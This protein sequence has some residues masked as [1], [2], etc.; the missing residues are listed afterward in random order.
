MVLGI[1]GMPDIVGSKLALLP[2]KQLS[3]S[4]TQIDGTPGVCLP[5]LV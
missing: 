4:Y 5:S 1:N 2:I 3:V